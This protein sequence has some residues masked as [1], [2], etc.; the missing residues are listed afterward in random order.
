MSIAYKKASKMIVWPK[1]LFASNSWKMS[2]FERSSWGQK[3][4]S[5]LCNNNSE[6]IIAQSCVVGG[7]GLGKRDLLEKGPFQKGPS[8]ESLEI[9]ESPQCVVV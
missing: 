9:L 1:R 6:G 4:L 5:E 8:V 2:I 3:V 7:I